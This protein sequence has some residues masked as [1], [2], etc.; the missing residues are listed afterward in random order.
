MERFEIDG[1][2]RFFELWAGLC[3][4]LEAVDQVENYTR[5]LEDYFERHRNDP[6][7]IES[8]EAF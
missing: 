2:P 5:Y 7:N 4:E 6:L 3:D 8:E 1:E